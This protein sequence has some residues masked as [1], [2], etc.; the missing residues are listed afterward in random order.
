MTGYVVE[1]ACGH[2]SADGAHTVSTFPPTTAA[3]VECVN[4]GRYVPTVVVARRG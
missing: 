3:V 1:L 4:C 2:G